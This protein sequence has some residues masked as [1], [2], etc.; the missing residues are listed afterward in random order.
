MERSETS[1]TVWPCSK[2]EP[3]SPLSVCGDYLEHFRGILDVQEYNINTIQ[4]N[5]GFGW[6]WCTGYLSK[7]VLCQTCSTTVSVESE[8]DAILWD[9]GFCLDFSDRDFPIL[10]WI[11][12]FSLLFLSHLLSGFPLLFWS[13]HVF[14]ALF[15]PFLVS[16]RLFC[17]FSISC[18]YFGDLYFPLLP[19]TFLIFFVLGT[20]PF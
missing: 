11:W 3:V 5:I 19:C 2:T 4:I 8:N 12:I 1:T 13:L 17:T 9:I 6:I 14:T 20:C 7:N 18:L 15:F 16:T 10:P